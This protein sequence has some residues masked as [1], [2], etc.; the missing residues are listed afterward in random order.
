[1]DEPHAGQLTVTWLG[2]SGL[3]A[4]QLLERKPTENEPLRQR[5]IARDWL[6]DFL[7]EEPRTS[8]EVWQSAEQAGLSERT[9]FRAKS[10]LGVTTERV[11]L[12]DKRLSYW[13][14][15]QQ[16]LPHDL[17]MAATQEASREMMQRLLRLGQ[18]NAPKQPESGEKQDESRL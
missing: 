16:Q 1:M 5:E 14:L 12:P 7:D 11:K 2:E 6:E 3:G 13:L 9:L 4:D 10:D 8:E 18:K 15:P 17:K